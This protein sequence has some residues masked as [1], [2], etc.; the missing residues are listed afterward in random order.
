MMKYFM[1]E[2]TFYNPLTVSEAELQGFIK[3]H[4]DYLAQ[5]FND[6]RILVSGPKMAGGGGVI[7]MKGSSLQEIE[8]Y[9]AK[10]PMKIAGI[11]EYKIIEFKLHNCQMILKEWFN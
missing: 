7:L 8:S 4:V 1:I 11:Q 9:F 2:S 3:A 10:D 6:G 5:G